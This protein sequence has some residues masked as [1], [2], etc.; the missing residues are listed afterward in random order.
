MPSFLLPQSHSAT[1]ESVKCQ[2]TFLK[3]EDL[4]RFRP[5]KRVLAKS[6]CET[7][8]TPPQA[9]L[10]HLWEKPSL[11]REFWWELTASGMAFTCIDNSGGT[12]LHIRLKGS[13]AME[14]T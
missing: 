3:R 2:D 10:P 14:V 9:A 11:A 12:G 7:R 5:A 1:S 6:L 13:L 4:S 8:N